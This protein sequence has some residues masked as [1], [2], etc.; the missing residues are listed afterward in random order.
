[1]N[2]VPELVNL[3]SADAQDVGTG[4]IL[5]NLVTDLFVS[6]GPRN[7]PVLARVHT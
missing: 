6:A 2:A 4:S 1:M 7:L 3:L 5:S